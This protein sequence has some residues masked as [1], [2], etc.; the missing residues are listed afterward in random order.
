MDLAR[1]DVESVHDAVFSEIARGADFNYMVRDA[2]Y[3]W[4]V[5]GKEEFLY[6][7]E[8]DPFELR[9][10]APLPAYRGDRDRLRERLRRFLMETQFNHAAGYQNLFTRMGLQVANEREMMAQLRE[11]FLSAQS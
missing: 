11:M 9:N 10:L 4:F 3:K 6:D 1:G 7:L 8:D 5:E 2:R